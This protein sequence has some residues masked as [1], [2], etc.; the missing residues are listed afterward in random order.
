MTLNEQFM[1]EVSRIKAPELFLGM[2]RLLEV[3]FVEG[4]I[5]PETDPKDLKM[6]DFTTLFAEIMDSFDKRDRHRKK[7]LLKLLRQANKEVER[8]GN[9][10]KDSEEAGAHKDLQ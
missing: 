8:D 1:I 5:S 3:G 4:E 2:A 10:S 7:E 9:N 6:K